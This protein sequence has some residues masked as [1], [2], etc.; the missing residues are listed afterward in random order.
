[1]AGNMG[2]H[3]DV[4]MEQGVLV[5]TLLDRELRDEQQCA[6]I[7]REFLTAV[8][9]EGAGKIAVDFRNV[10][11]V[12]SVGFRPPL[13]LRRLAHDTG[14]RLVQSRPI[15][16]GGVLGHPPHRH[17]ANGKR[18]VRSQAGPGVGHRLLESRCGDVRQAHR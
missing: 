2:Q 12:A 15:R 16:R 10:T 3:V 4:A 18:A 7:R 17:A 11:F 1:M 8:N 13:S 5:L 6:A 14:A 9:E